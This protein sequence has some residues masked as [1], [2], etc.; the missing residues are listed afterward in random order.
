[1]TYPERLNGM[2]EPFD[3]LKHSKLEF[4]KPDL[5]R[6]TCLALAFEAIRQ[7]GSMPCFM[8][9]ANEVLVHR[10]LQGELKWHEIGIRLEDLMSRHQVRQADDLDAILAIDQEARQVASRDKVSYQ[11]EA[12][13]APC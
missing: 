3:F 1:L 6:F 2:L 10:F 13:A 7:G 8:N 11:K 4:F 5:G 9:A 12:A